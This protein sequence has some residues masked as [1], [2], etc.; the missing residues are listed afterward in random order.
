MQRWQRTLLGLIMDDPETVSTVLVDQPAIEHLDSRTRAMVKVAAA[1]ATDAPNIMLQRVVSD[2]VDAGASEDDV[3]GVLVVCGPL[4]GASRLIRTAPAVAAGLDFDA[5]GP[6]ETLD[7]AEGTL[8][9]LD[10][11]DPSRSSGIGPGRG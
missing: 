8:A 3:V 6:L 1:C 10:R 5:D 4:I 2:A 9:G 7:G 11:R